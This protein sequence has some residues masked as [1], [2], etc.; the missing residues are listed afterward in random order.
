MSSGR[1]FFLLGSGSI[2][3]RNPII[4]PARAF[5]DRPTRRRPFPGAPEHPEK[6]GSVHE[7]GHSGSTVLRQLSQPERSRG[8]TDGLEVWGRWKRG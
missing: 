1:A 5:C 6:T 8:R 2:R 4:V 7:P 3:C